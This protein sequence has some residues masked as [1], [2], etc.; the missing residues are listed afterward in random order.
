LLDFVDSLENVPDLAGLYEMFYQ[1][2]DD[3]GQIV[4]YS[5]AMAFLHQHDI[6]LVKSLMLAEG[7]GFSLLV[8]DSEKLASLLKSDMLRA[9]LIRYNFADCY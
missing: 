3:E 9:E 6:M 1:L 8:L 5:E 2:A 7:Y 4:T